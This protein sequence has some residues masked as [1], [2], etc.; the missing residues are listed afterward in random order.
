MAIKT[1]EEFIALVRQ[2]ESEAESQPTFYKVKLAFFAVFGYLIIFLVLAGLLGLA[3][4]L[5][6]MAFFSTGLFLLLLKKK[7]IFAVLAGIWVLLRALWIK[8]TPPSGYS[9]QRTEFPLLFI[10]LDKLRTELNALK[11]HQVILDNSLNAAVVQHPRLGILG[12]H[13]NYLI[14]GYQLLLTLSP[15]EMRAVLAHEFGHLSGNHSRFGGWIYRV[16]LSWLRVMSAFEQVDSWGGK[17]MRKFFA[18][19]S[20]KFDALSFAFARSNEFSADAVSAEL[21]SAETA[22]RA[23]ITVYA[24]APY[25]ERS[26]WSHYLRYA[27]DFPVPPYAPF[28]GLSEFL[29]TKP[30]SDEELQ[31]RIQQELAVATHYADTHP[32]L[33]D[34]VEALGAGVPLPGRTEVNAAEAW[35]GQNNAMVMAQFDQKWMDDYLSSWSERHQYASH[36][37]IK[38]AEYAAQPVA[39][40]SDQ[41]L[42]DFACWT[43]EFADPAQAITQLMAYQQRFPHHPEAAF[44]IGSEL[45]EQKNADGLQQL[46]IA[47]KSPA[48]IEQVAHLGYQYLIEQQEEDKAQAWWQDCLAQ[49]AIFIAASQERASVSVNDPLQKART[50]P[51]LLQQLQDLLQQFS[52]IGQVWIAEKQVQHFPEDPVYILALK[53]KF[54]R[55]CATDIAAKVAAKLNLRA[56]VFVCSTAGL[57]HSKAL[58][59]KV[60]KAG[61]K[62]I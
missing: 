28:A 50:E 41:D 18:W 26:Y 35:L 2:A 5:I 25:L 24:S 9:L 22:S 3:G 7:L 32:S 58:A 11:I 29:K 44:F 39:E 46:K 12:W 21:T 37:K 51:E 60:I 6:A 59:K 42:W 45:L 38:L 16:R 15:A 4:G 36:A 20:P 49:N 47:A 33:K 53:P 31:S 61:E 40:L 14:L 62:L 1:E 56:S 30:Q 8:F 23:L 54:Y 17:L 27:D 52:V 57:G 55:Y 43:R 10:E 19:Y 48:L 13:Q 34:R